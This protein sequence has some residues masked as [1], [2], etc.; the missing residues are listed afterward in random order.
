MPVTKPEAN[1]PEDVQRCSELRAA[2]PYQSLYLCGST[3]DSVFL[4]MQR[5]AS[6]VGLI[7]QGK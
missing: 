6:E 4:G 5:V 1:F 3:Q 7:R 2:D